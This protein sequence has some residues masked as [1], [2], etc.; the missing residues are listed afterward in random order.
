VNRSDLTSR[1]PEFITLAEARM[2]RDLRLRNIQVLDF[3]AS[4]QYA[5]P[6]TFKATVDLYHDGGDNWGRIKMVSPGE[7]SERKARHG[8]L[9]VPLFASVIDGP[10][11][12]NQHYLR[13][14][15]EPSGSYSLRMI[16]EGD[17]ESLS[18]SN[19][20]NWLLD[21]SP[22]IYLWATLAC[23]EGYLQEDERVGLWKKEYDQAVNEF[24]RNQKAREHSGPLTPRPTHIIG[25]DV[26]SY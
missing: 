7:L 14:A 16:Y 1:I 12:A 6:S 25:E 24:E 23:A 3:T 22:D 21:S 10:D 9:G 17:L 5:L 26:R 8:D 19:T 11:D 2:R 15:P 18:D 20:T 13:F 4:E